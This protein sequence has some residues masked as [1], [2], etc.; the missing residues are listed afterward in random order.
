VFSGAA[1]IAENLQWEFFSFMVGIWITLLKEQM[2]EVFHAEDKD[3]PRG[4]QAL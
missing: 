1:S 3:Q 2:T 4:R